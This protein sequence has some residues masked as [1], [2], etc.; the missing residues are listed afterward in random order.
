[1]GNN[2]A[3]SKLYAPQINP[4]KRKMLQSKVVSSQL[5]KIPIM[6]ITMIK[7]QIISGIKRIIDKLYSKDKNVNINKR[8]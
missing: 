1:M 6:K 3:I 4:K 5:Y 8:K 2:S 7:K